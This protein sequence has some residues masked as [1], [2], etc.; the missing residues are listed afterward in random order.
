M[1][2]FLVSLLW[3]EVKEFEKTSERKKAVRYA[4]RGIF[5]NGYY[6]LT[7]IV[8]LVVM[9]RLRLSI[10]VYLG[11]SRLTQ[12]ILAG[13]IGGVLGLYGGCGAL[14][15]SR[16]TIRMRLR[17]RLNLAG[18]PVCMSCG[19][20]LEGLPGDRCPECGTPV[21]VESSPRQEGRKPDR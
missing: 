15:F 20:S 7:L 19:Y 5:F 18:I 21:P 6:L 2:V 4:T 13:V 3:P 9:V 12:L 11:L 1:N 8:L 14:L 10:E 17:E 16:K